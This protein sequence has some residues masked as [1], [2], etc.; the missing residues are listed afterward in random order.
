MYVMV[1]WWG[2]LIAG[3]VFLDNSRHSHTAHHAASCLP[4]LYIFLYQNT[5][6][7]KTSFIYVYEDMY[8]SAYMYASYPAILDHRPRFSSDNRQQNVKKAL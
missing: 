1:W 4:A 2:R 8:L 6:G 3:W 5:V 7:S